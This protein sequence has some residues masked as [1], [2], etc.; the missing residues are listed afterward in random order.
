V[1]TVRFPSAPERFD[2]VHL[3]SLGFAELALQLQAKF[4][5]PLV[6]TSHS[7]VHAELPR[8]SRTSG[9]GSVQDRVLARS[10]HVLFPSLAER[11]AT[12]ARLPGLEHRSSVH[13]NGS[14]RAPSPPPAAART[15]P[16]VFA[17]RFSESKGLSLLSEVVD[18]LAGQP[19]IRFTF[20][21]GHGD[22]QGR[23]IVTEL[24]ERHP[25]RCR[26]S[27]WLAPPALEQLFAAASMVVVPSRYEPFGMVALEAMRVGA[28]VLAAA[29]GG[30]R[31]VVG[32]GSGGLLVH[33][34]RAEDWCAAIVH[35][36]NAPELR[37]TLAQRGPAYVAEH[38]DPDTLARALVERIYQPLGAGRVDAMTAGAA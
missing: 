29:T 8:W 9:W 30:L 26:V 34:R 20:A 37:A 11:T 23:R 19:G 33:S 21:G 32:P 1:A 15:G 35:L 16:V 31:E 4:G 10:D 22:E 17:G 38:F 36:W 7:S 24:V 13:R 14:V 12:V 2:V 28:P 27:G 3:H 6:Y 5:L 18:R 25:D